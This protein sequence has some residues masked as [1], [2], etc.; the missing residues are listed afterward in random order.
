MSKLSSTSQRE[1]GNNTTIKS[2]M[3]ENSIDINDLLD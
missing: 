2:Y 3:L 1:I